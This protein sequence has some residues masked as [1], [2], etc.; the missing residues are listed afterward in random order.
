MALVDVF[1]AL[2]HNR[3]YK[4]AWSVEDA[5]TYILNERGR[6]FDPELVDVFIDAL[7]RILGIMDEFPS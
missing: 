5:K 7:P 1:D 3:I 4:P 2:T 6:H